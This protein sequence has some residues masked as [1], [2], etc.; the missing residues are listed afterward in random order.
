MLVILRDTREQD[1][2]SFTGV[3]GVDKVE[4]IG[5]LYGDYACMIDGKKCPVFFERKGLGDLFSTMTH[6][7]DRFKREMARAKEHGHKLILI[8]EG[9]YSDVL[10]GYS[11]SEFSGEAMVKKLQTLRIKYDLEWWPCMN[12][13]EMAHQIASTFSAI[14]RDWDKK[15]S[16][17]LKTSL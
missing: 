8:T 10:D 16:C 17:S 7:Y 11:H 3:D 14:Q 5:L 2:L 6:G 12:R 4:D 1:P 15:D 13:K 9:T